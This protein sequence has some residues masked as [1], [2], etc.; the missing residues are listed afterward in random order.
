MFVLLFSC[1]GG[2]DQGNVNH[3][4]TTLPYYHTADFDPIWNPNQLDTFHRIPTFS[5]C[6]QLGETVNN[7]RMYGHIYVCNFFFTRCGGVCPK[8][9]RNMAFLQENTDESV[10]F[11]SHS[12]LP[13]QDSIAQLFTYAQNFSINHQRW[14]LLTGDKDE[15]YNIARRGYFAEKQLGVNKDSS[16]FL[17]TEHFMLIDQNG[18]IR[19]LYNGTLLLEMERILDDIHLLQNEPVSDSILTSYPSRHQTRA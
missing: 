3:M 9:M 8:M 4:S 2:D 7:Q 18:Y 13:E 11:L 14:S 10:Y 16:E 15:I 12:V 6:N 5:F 19:G 17:H 1:T